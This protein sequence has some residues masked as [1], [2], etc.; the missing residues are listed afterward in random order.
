LLIKEE[1]RE[2]SRTRS[3]R[4]ASQKGKHHRHEARSTKSKHLMAKMKQ[5]ENDLL[6]IILGVKGGRGQ[7]GRRVKQSA[8]ARIG[9]L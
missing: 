9:P 3:V 2:K 1:G 5:K 8:S 4:E 6:G 7:C